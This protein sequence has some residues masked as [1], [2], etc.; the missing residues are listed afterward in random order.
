MT[1][2]GR[3]KNEDDINLLRF[4][5]CTRYEAHNFFTQS[6]MVIFEST[7]GVCSPNQ[8]K[9]KATAFT[10]VVD[11]LIAD[12]VSV[13]PKI[14]GFFAA[15]TRPVFNGDMTTTVYAVA[16]CVETISQKDCQSC[17]T[18]GYSNIQS[19]PP[20]S[21]GSSVDAG[22]FLRYSDS[23]FFADSSI[24]NITP[25]LPGGGGDFFEL[26]FLEEKIYIF[27]KAYKIV[28][29]IYFGSIQVSSHVEFSFTT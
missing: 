2:L 7:A 18:T 5:V 13:I 26:N 16:Q 17:L 20:A 21:G 23:S 12:L 28:N 29:I 27:Q 11:G 10:P 14:D 1:K 8:S 15:T 6:L 9:F 24:I 22:C 19:C 3:I 25:Y 4:F